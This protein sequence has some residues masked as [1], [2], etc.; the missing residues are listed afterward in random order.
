MHGAQLLHDTNLTR[1]AAAPSVQFRGRADGRQVG[2]WGEERARAH[3]RA[4]SRG[5]R[6]AQSELRARIGPASEDDAAA[7]VHTS[8]HYGRLLADTIRSIKRKQ[9]GSCV[10]SDEEDVRRGRGR[11]H[12]AAR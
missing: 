9:Y 11:A 3:A 6:S 5:S 12:S 2:E 7:A 10:K 1:A 4:H 8:P